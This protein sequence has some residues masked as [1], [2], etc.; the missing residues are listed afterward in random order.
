[1]ILEKERKQVTAGYLK[2]N[3]VLAP[4]SLKLLQHTSLICIKTGYASAI[5]DPSYNSLISLLEGVQNR[6]AHFILSNYHRTA[7]V[8]S[9]NFSLHLPNLSTSRKVSCLCL[10]HKI[11][12]HPIL[13][14]KL[15]ILC[16]IAR[17]SY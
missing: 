2:Q 14:E 10:F 5:G 17:G 8:M 15:K 13:L 7:S 11:Y 9:I 6:S 4:S 1:M 12:H 3:F 16:L